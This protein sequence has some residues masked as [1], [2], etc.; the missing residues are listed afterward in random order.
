MLCFNK[1]SSV[2][3]QIFEGGEKTDEARGVRGSC[4]D[5]SGTV[6]AL[7]V[8]LDHFIIFTVA[9]RNRT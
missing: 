7:E 5:D 6:C 4:T 1:A 3:E 8:R 2:E 9:E